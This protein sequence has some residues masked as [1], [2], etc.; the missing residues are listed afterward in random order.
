MVE[1]EYR[2]PQVDSKTEG[3]HTRI[4]VPADKRGLVQQSSTSA[5]LFRTLINLFFSFVYWL[6]CCS[7]FLCYADS[8]VKAYTE[9]FLPFLKSKIFWS[10]Q[11]DVLFSVVGYCILMMVIK[12]M[13]FRN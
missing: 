4:K 11:R 13:L 6:F 5:A 10:F 3:D 1:I 7:Y 12:I 2:N 8:M 9:G